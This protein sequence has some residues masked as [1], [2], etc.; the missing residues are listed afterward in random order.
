MQFFELETG[1]VLVVS[2]LINLTIIGAFVNFSE[3]DKL[4]ELADAGEAL[5]KSLGSMAKYIWALGL[6]SSGQSATLAGTLTGQYILEGFLTLQISK[7]KRI[8]LSRLLTLL[9]CIF[10]AKYAQ[11]QIVYIMLNVVQF[12]QL[13]F[14][15]IPL[16]KIIENTEIM[17]GVRIGKRRLNILKKISLFFVIMNLGQ[18]IS[19][20]TVQFN[21][22]VL[23][24][25]LLSFYVYLL[26][27][28]FIKK[29][30]LQD[31]MIEL[32][33]TISIDC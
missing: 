17:G 20:V 24:L 1:I 28:L 9:P 4:I 25:L 22:I 13:P 27:R 15:L 11:V 30:R 19:T 29:L 21:Y 8:V 31:G 16:F 5:S 14:V 23:I 3:Q 2:C 33:E 10:I 26:W 7:S 18:I 32:A 6:F 12:I